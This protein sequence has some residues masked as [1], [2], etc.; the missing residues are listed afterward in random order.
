MKSELQPFCIIWSSKEQIKHYMP[1]VFKESYAD[2][3]SIID[4][5]EIKMESLSSLD[6]QSLCY[7]MYKSH[8]TMKGLIGITANGVVSFASELYCGSISDAEIVEKSGCYNHCTKV[9][10]SWLIKASS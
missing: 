1:P 8:T 5:T 4:C 9:I 10:L 2:F 6:N 7:S 3:V